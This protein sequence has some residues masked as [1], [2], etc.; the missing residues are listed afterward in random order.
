MSKEHLTYFKVENFKRFDSLELTGIGQF[1]L[2]VG[3]N[4][5]GKTSVL[6]AI[7]SL[8]RINEKEEPFR[9][10]FDDFAQILIRRGIN[11]QG[12][13]DMF[14]NYLLKH[15]NKPII[16]ETNISG[17]GSLKIKLSKSNNPNFIN[18]QVKKE[19]SPNMEFKVEP[20]NAKL[21]SALIPANIE[22]NGNLPDE[23]QKVLNYSRANKR[24]II[25]NLKVIDQ[26]IVD[27][28]VLP[29]ITQSHV[30]IGYEN[31]DRYLPLTSMGESA[32]RVFYYLL[33]II[34]N[35]GHRLLIDEIDTG[36]HYSRMKNF[37]KILFQIAIKNEVQLFL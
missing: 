37:L 7:A 32:V 23:Y 6:E 14:F 2:V 13:V 8:A 11:V 4:N 28:E 24:L 30:M 29:I 35:S 16:I 22:I 3:D 33:R 15:E 9:K 12:N 31:D 1:N 21:P 26:R 18:V 36:I 19:S 25:D 5:A 34:S 10:S 27:I 17:H 20:T